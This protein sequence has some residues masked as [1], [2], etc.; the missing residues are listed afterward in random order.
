MNNCVIDCL[1]ALL[2]RYLFPVVYSLPTN[3]AE[4]SENLLD[5]WTGK[6]NRRRS[7]AAAA[8]GCLWRWWPTSRWKFS[9]SRLLSTPPFASSSLNCTNPSLPRTILLV[10]SLLHFV[11][12]CSFYGCILEMV[13]IEVSWD[14]CLRPFSLWS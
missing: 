4:E 6:S 2:C 10:F 13:K 14:D 9:A 11:K 8:E 12:F 3:L 7:R 5:W 1:F